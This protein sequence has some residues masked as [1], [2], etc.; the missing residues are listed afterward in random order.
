MKSKSPP[1]LIE[2]NW[3]LQIKIT[4]QVVVIF[5]RYIM[6]Q[7]KILSQTICMLFMAI[8]W[9][10]CLCGFITLDHQ[11]IFHDPH[12][13]IYILHFRLIFHDIHTKIVKNKK[14]LWKSTQTYLKKNNTSWVLMTKTNI[15]TINFSPIKEIFI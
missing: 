2:T 5:I 8:M 9:I 11:L 6:I 4:W 15:M 7:L 1:N 12:T 13:K 14:N 3:I 10:M